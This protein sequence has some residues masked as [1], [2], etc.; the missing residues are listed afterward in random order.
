MER[1]LKYCFQWI[2]SRCN[3]AN[4]VRYPQYWWRWVKCLW[5]SYDEFKRDMRD[6]FVSHYNKYWSRNTTIDRIDNNWNYCKKNCR[7]V[8]WIE[9]RYNTTRTRIYE[10][11]PLKRYCDK[12]WISYSKVLA[13]VNYLWWTI[14]EAVN[15]RDICKKMYKSVIQ[16]DLCGSPIKEYK[17]IS[18]ASKSSWVWL[19]GI[20]QCLN[21]KYRQS[22]WYKWEYTTKQS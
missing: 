20:A 1:K 22:W 5:V 19:W 3:N 9:Q 18:E 17:S 11:I 15:W 8:T 13:R 2:K 16:K 21:W 6:T 10:G 4:N 7:W 12:K 14:E